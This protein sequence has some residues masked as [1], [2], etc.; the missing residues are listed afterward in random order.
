MPSIDSR[1]NSTSLL[2]QLYLLLRRRPPHSRMCNTR[3]RQP[4]CM[5]RTRNL[6]SITRDITRT[7]ML[8]LQLPSPIL[9]PLNSHQM[10]HTQ[11]WRVMIQHRAERLL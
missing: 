3:R 2:Q 6:S 1:L 5:R 10:A 11:G 9:D 7:T 8:P 4:T